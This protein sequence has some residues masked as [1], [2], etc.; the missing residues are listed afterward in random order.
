[1]ASQC[2]SVS[3]EEFIVDMGPVENSCEL[4]NAQLQNLSGTLAGRN[5]VEEVTMTIIRELRSLGKMID[6]VNSAKNHRMFRQREVNNRINDMSKTIGN[7]CMQLSAGLDE[8][9]EAK[10]SLCRI[11]IAAGKLEILSIT[12][13]QRRSE[14][15]FTETMPSGAFVS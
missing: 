4:L 1:M 14:N 13:I 15:A 5:G 8:E 11:E 2:A 9:S 10:K 7:I 12:V 6:N 3:T